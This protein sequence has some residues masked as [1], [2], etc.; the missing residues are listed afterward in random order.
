M[1]QE[2]NYATKVV[3][4]QFF[5]EGRR[6]SIHV[7]VPGNKLSDTQDQYKEAI[8]LYGHLMNEIRQRDME[9]ERMKKPFFL[10]GMF[11]NK[12]FGRKK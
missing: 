1:D 4:M 12:M 2:I 5:L 7:P 8:D 3:R 9:I 6:S 10:K 11:I